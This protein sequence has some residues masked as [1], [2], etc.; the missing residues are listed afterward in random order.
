MVNLLTIYS[1]R[2]VKL[3]DEMGRDGTD[4]H[5]AW[6]EWAY[7]RTQSAQSIESNNDRNERANPATQ[8]SY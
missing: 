3:E 7:Q 1:G 8:F 4:L 6:S 2:Q 5:K